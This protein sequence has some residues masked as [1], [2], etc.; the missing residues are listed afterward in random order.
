MSVG[1]K[2]VS[3]R[4]GGAIQ[5]NRESEVTT[6]LEA[7]SRNMVRSAVRLIGIG[8]PRQAQSSGADRSPTQ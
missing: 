3:G 7:T 6:A 2:P 4:Y 5:A 8:I 1:S